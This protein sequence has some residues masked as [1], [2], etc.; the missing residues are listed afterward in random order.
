MGRLRDGE[1]IAGAGGLGLVVALF[2]H[3]YSVPLPPVGAAGFPGIDALQASG[4]QAF[5]VTD[6]L[7][8]LLALVPLALVVLQATR[9]SP[10][11]P[12]A[13]SVFATI[14]G[15]LAT[16]L[17]LYRLVNQPGPNELVDVESG[18]WL[19]LA[20]ALAITAGGWR[21]MRVE[22]VPG[23]AIPPIEE[24]PAPAP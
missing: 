17:V 20:A 15:G 21:S 14:A 3:W 2:L 10:S 9:T 16:L 11:I 22:G 12:V 19:A 18:A 23:A 6:V 1:W 7:L 24:Q 4:W 13:F 8:A 5:S